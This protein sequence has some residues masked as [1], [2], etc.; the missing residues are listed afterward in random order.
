MTPA[1]AVPS[2]RRT[3]PGGARTVNPLVNSSPDEVSELLALLRGSGIS[4]LCLDQYSGCIC[5]LES[6]HLERHWC[7]CGN[8]WEWAEA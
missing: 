5:R 4:T 6:E 2:P 8:E 3:G 7:V 1:G